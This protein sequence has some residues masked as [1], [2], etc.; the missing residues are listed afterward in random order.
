LNLDTRLQYHR[1][2]LA[3]SAESPSER[4][5][6]LAEEDRLTH[7]ALEVFVTLR[8]LGPRLVAYVPSI[9]S[10]TELERRVEPP[11]AYI[12]NRWQGSSSDVPAVIRPFVSS[13]FTAW[14]DYAEWNE[15]T[16][17]CSWRIEPSQN[18]TIFSCVGLTSIAADG[19]ER[20]IFRLEAELTLRPE[21]VRGVPK[22]LA[23]KI[24]EPMERYMA[25]TLRP[26]LTSMSS[27]VQQYLDDQKKSRSS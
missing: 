6:Q 21:N 24:R 9:E 18:K 12:H 17:S 14:V 7:P 5:M 10:M 16:L 11:I 4:M 25:R 19:P 1:R 23:K 2:R 15:E 27:A 13:D 3:G 20:S 8:D 22:F 26:N